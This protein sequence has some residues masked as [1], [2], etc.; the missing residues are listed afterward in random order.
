MSWIHG[1]TTHP[2]HCYNWS[3]DACSPVT[4]S[5][6]LPSLISFLFCSFPLQ[7]FASRVIYAFPFYTIKNDP[8]V[9]NKS[10]VP[11]VWPNNNKMKISTYYNIFI[12][13]ATLHLEIK[14]NCEKQFPFDTM[15]WSNIFSQAF[16]RRFTAIAR[17]VAS[18]GCCVPMDVTVH[19]PQENNLE[20]SYETTFVFIMY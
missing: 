18:P 5:S 6:F 20:R 10:W 9:Q 8:W 1:Y 11:W 7:T 13:R 14:K 17:T 15:W 16:W 12:R 4:S 3:P 19:M 2:Y